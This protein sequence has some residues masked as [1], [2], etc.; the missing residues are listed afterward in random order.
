MGL[1]SGEGEDLSL[2]N[3]LLGAMEKAGAD[4]TGTFRAL[5]GHLRGEPLALTKATQNPGPLNPW[6]VR[7]EERLLR[8]NQDHMSRAV[9]MD[10]VSPLYIPRN[11][12]VEEA[13]Q[14]ASHSGDLSLFEKLL[15][16][17]AEPFT[18]R[19][20]LEDYEKPAPDSAAPYVTYC[21]T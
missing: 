10:R 19:E 16:V 4:Y 5:S 9:A 18:K 7:W 20:G 12:K 14:A 17:T 13:L 21:G 2:A 1:V 11:H 8:D 3:D 6:I 15:D